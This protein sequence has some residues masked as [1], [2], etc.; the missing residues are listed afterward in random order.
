MRPAPIALD[1]V[2]QRRK[3]GVFG[4]VLLVLGIAVVGMEVEQFL[5][6]RT[7]LNERERIV[8]RMRHQITRQRQTTL[9]ED[10]DTPV[11]AEERG[12]ALKLRENLDR[13]WP[14]LFADIAAAGGDQI[15]VL[16]V[17]PDGLRGQVLVQASTRQL[18]AM[19]DYMARLE[20]TGA[21]QGVELQA[22]EQKN[23][24][25]VFSLSARWPA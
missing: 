11:S 18:K 20:A 25:F 4:W 16:G 6:R 1:F 3:P 24:G 12:P 13:D 21:L 15:A 14:A 10:D 19:F 17:S 22:F 23:G 2:P 5:L 9:A 8:E 7:D